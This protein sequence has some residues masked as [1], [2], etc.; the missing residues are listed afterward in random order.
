MAK[1][2]KFGG[3]GRKEFVR[4]RV[5]K[6]EVV[7]SVFILLLLVAVGLAIYRKGQ[8]YDPNLYQIRTE[9]LKSTA[10][11]VE[12]KAGTVPTE[13]SPAIPASKKDVAGNSAETAVHAG[14]GEAG[15]EGENAE[16][17]PV[18][19]NEPLQIVLA[20][21]KP[22]GETEFYNADNLYEKIDGRAPA[23]QSFNVQQLRCRSFGV[24]AAPGSFVDL[25]EYRFNSPVNA[26]GMFAQERDP[27]GQPLEFV[28]DGCSSE[29]GYFFR[30]G[31]VY[32]QIIASDTKPAT[33]AI[34]RSIA[35]IRA[36]NLPVDDQG[37]VGRRKL[38]AEGMIAGSVEFV[39]E[40][41]QGQAA[42]K[43]MFQ[44]KY[45]FEGAEL[46]FFVMVTTQDNAANAWKSFQNF[47]GK[48][49]TVENLPEVNGA[50]LFR[51]RVFDKW[52][53]VYQRGGE[54]GGAYDAGDAET[55][56]DFVEKYLRGEMK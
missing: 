9:A 30:Q 12:G 24:V 10:A 44:A 54:L 13:A 8:H 26:F 41:A 33:L 31:P 4:T 50:Q 21:T 16:S 7:S 1:D 53:V 6:V 29:M 37:L 45:K 51:A 3:G 34:A 5:P 19:K 20:G 42:L 2:K 22:L 23:Y 55:A 56:R 14:Y 35:D 48:F 39:R 38:P 27:K 11:A 49:G 52:K 25:Y 32:V 47:C 46:A 28:A 17:K 40:N 18:L 15:V 36:K 43:E